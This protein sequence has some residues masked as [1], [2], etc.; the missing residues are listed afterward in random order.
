[1]VTIDH[2]R[3]CEVDPVVSGNELAT[4]DNLSTGLHHL[5]ANVVA[6]EKPLRDIDEKAGRTTMAYGNI[7]GL[8]QGTVQILPCF[9][10]WYGT[11]LINYVRLVGFLSG[12]SSGKFTR[13]D[14]EDAKNF[15]VVT[16]FCD[17]YVRSISEL[18]AVKVWRDKVAAHFAITAPKKTKNTHDNPVFLDFSVMYP[19]GFESGRF[20]VGLLRLMRSD[21]MGNAQTGE[22]PSWSLTE[23]HEAL[24]PRY[25]NSL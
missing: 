25:W 4:L 22:L 23:T 20:R 21:S 7:P 8:R 13:A 15:R 5:Y 6:V 18:S 9:F 10:H 19:V 24:Q 3:G 2:I 12:I 17:E 16:E 14:L 1:M 11:T